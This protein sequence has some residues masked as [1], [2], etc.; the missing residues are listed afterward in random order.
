MI[1]IVQAASHEQIGNVRDLFIEYAHSLN[2]SLC[3]ENLDKEVNELPGVYAPPRGSL[4]LAADGEKIAGCVA[5]KK[6]DDRVCEMKRLY[7]RAEF[8]GRGIGKRLAMQI[9]DEAREIGYER[10]R[11]DT[12]PS[13]KEAISLYRSL[14]F[15]E[16]PAYREL[17]VPGALFMQVKL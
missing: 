15:E 7:V 10:F 3:F 12:L 9:V 8:R 6:V 5:L 11:L 4:L 1:Q 17:P 14:G 13:M 16:I 2:V